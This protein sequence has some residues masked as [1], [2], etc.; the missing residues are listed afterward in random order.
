MEYYIGIALLMGVEAVLFWKL[1]YSS[2]MFDAMKQQT[3]TEQVKL[4][5]K[6]FEED[7]DE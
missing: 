4:W 6:M 3:Q 2:G 1:G 7:D 5:Q